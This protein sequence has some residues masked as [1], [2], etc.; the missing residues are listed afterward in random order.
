M[1]SSTIAGDRSVHFALVELDLLATHAGVPFP[2]PLR[3]PSFGRIAGERDALLTEA[4]HAL[5]ARGLADRHGP[6]GVA[7]DL[8]TAL[9]EHRGAVDVVVLGA[10]AATGVVAMVHRSWVVVCGQSLGAEPAGMVRVRRVARTEVADA[11]AEAVPDVPAAVT[12]PVTLPPGAVRAA[13][14]VLGGP[15]DEERQR[16]RDLLDDHGGDPDAVDRLTELLAT[17]VGRGQLGATRRTEG[18][19]VRDGAEL[20]WLDG[21]RGRVRIDT[22]DDGWTS[23]NPLRRSELLRELSAAAMVAREPW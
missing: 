4:G 17:V 3:V 5:A 2:Y 10:G 14:R 18:G 16:L 21:P 15:V 19:A 23:V 11:L 1:T 9:R 20:S 7:A 13:S 6:R 22:A 12:I 8:V